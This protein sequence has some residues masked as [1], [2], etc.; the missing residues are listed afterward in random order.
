MI[1]R[2][3]RNRVYGSG[4]DQRIIRH[5]APRGQTAATVGRFPYSTA[6]RSNVSNDAA[7]RG[8]GRIDSNRVH[9]ALSQ[10]VIK[11]ARASGHPLRLWTER[12]KTG[13]AQSVRVA[14]IKLTMLP[15]R[16]TT[17][18]PIVLRRGRCAPIWD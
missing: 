1:V 5:D 17:L 18:H 4:A 3:D 12:R 14:E 16:D 10:R 15:Q 13:G 11:A 7:V 6:N 2:I 8:R 9:P